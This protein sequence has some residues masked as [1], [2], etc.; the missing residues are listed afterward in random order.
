MPDFEGNEFK[1]FLNDKPLTVPVEV[2]LE[3][4]RRAIISK[5]KIMSS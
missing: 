1:I 4:E 5:Q 3:T 2:E